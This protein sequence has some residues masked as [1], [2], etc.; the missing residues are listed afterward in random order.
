MAKKSPFIFE[1]G[2]LH[3]PNNT[4]VV[5]NSSVSVRFCNNGTGNLYERIVF[6]DAMIALNQNPKNAIEID[7]IINKG[8]YISNQEDGSLDVGLSFVNNTNQERASK[9]IR[10][11]QKKGE[12]V[13]ITVINTDYNSFYIKGIVYEHFAHDKYI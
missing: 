10:S 11:F 12:E 6:S 1:N 8:I 3:N 4:F 2:V 5:K 13:A 9:K 7:A